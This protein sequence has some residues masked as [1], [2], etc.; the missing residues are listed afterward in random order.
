MGVIFEDANGYEIK[1]NKFIATQNQVNEAVKERIEDGD[2]IVTDTQ[3]NEVL[4]KMVEDGELNVT[5]S[6]DVI[7]NVVNTYL[8]ENP[9]QS[10]ATQEQ[11]EQIQKNKEDISNLSSEIDGLISGEIP[12]DVLYSFDDFKRDL[13]SYTN[14]NS[15]CYSIENGIVKIKNYLSWIYKINPFDYKLGDRLVLSIR[16]KPMKPTLAQ[17]RITF[18]V[19]NY[20]GKE[21]K[22]SIDLFPN[23]AYEFGN[24]VN[25]VLYGEEINLTVVTDVTIQ[26]SLNKFLD[27]K[28]SNKLLNDFELDILDYKVYVYRDSYKTK[29]KNAEN[30][31]SAESAKYAENISDDVKEHLKEDIISSLSNPLKDK[32]WGAIGDSLTATWFDVYVSHVANNTEL[33]PTN[34]GIGGTCVANIESADVKPSFVD[35]I[36]GLNGQSGYTE[37]R[38]LWSVFGGTNDCFKNVPIGNINDTTDNTFYGALNLII[39]HLL[40]MSNHPTVVLVTPYHLSNGNIKNYVDA[41]VNIG[42]KYGLPVLNLYDLSGINDVNRS[43][44]LRDIA[45]PTQAGANKLR[46]IINKFFGDIVLAEE[47]DN[48]PH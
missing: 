30:A 19:M 40:S 6:E 3:L 44:Y 41:I 25:N 28:M 35:R 2:K 32:T 21:N 20:D 4:N 27:I 13:P 11:V 26:N 29:V 23:S 38:D 17:Q 34:Y 36:C 1:V 18:G 10:G 43:Y 33:I 24:P 9:V 14:Y 39:T 5:P 48:M 15:N 42:S 8:E 7:T 46:P 22:V 47:T 45:H 31:E 37:T 12:K 16:L